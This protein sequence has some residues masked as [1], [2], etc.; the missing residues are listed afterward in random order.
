MLVILCEVGRGSISWK[1]FP[2]LGK[3]KKAKDF[4]WLRGGL[5]LATKFGSGFVICDSELFRLKS[6]SIKEAENI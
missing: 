1:M 4:E 3:D 6:T 2:E 5:Y